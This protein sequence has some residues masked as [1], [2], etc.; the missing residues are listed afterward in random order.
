MFNSWSGCL[1]AAALGAFLC[2]PAVLAQTK[3]APAATGPWAKVPA[4]TT[5]CYYEGDPFEAKLTAALAA[6]NASRTKQLAINEK[7]ETEHKNI[8]PMEMA[9][10]MQQWMMSN[11][12]E[13]TKY[14]QGVQ[15][16]G[17]DFNARMPEITAAQQRFDAEEKALLKR[18][19]TTLDTA[20]APAYAGH[21]ALKKRLGVPSEY[22]TVKSESG[23]TPAA[24]VAEENAIM[25]QLDAA[26]ATNCTQFWGATGQVPTW[27]KTYRAWLTQEFIPFNQRIASQNAQ[28]YAIM[29]TPAAT[30]KDTA[31]F[32]GVIKYLEAVGRVY[33]NRR[34]KPRCTAADCG[35]N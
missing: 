3:P 12:Q 25:R 21:A 26:Y 19:Q 1:A 17:E 11:P 9:S 29:S 32:D 16:V 2:A 35:Y 6:V 33:G 15:A 4:F 7:V 5:A 27:L 23:S 8:D 10:R 18:Y 30:W 28:T 24:A 13:A 20:S 31:E 34:P 22:P 14:M